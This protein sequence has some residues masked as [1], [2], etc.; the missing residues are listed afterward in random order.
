MVDSSGERKYVNLWALKLYI[1]SMHGLRPQYVENA[2]QPRSA[3]LNMHANWS[4][5]QRLTSQ[6][7]DWSPANVNSCTTSAA[8]SEAN[9]NP[10]R[11]SLSPY[12]ASARVLQVGRITFFGN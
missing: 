7:A 1:A 6:S 8:T 3:G 12:Q 4:R 11:I 2:G 10:S 9:H 5:M